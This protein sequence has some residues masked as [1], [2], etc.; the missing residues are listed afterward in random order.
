MEYTPTSSAS[1]STAAPLSDATA[2]TVVITAEDSE[3]FTTGPLDA[4]GAM[5]EI[6]DTEPL[7]S[8]TPGG[9]KQTKKSTPVYREQLLL[10]Y[11]PG[12]SHLHFVMLYSTTKWREGF[13]SE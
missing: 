2:N 4:P 7:T 13:Y 10:R 5:V 1:L 8:S 3:V 6:V 9:H 11:I 12:A